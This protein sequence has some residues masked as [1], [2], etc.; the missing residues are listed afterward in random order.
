[1]IKIGNNVN[2]SFQPIRIAD[3]NKTRNEINIPFKAPLS[4]MSEVAIRNPETTQRKKADKLA[5]HVRF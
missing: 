2:G 1:M 4:L 5:S 3:G